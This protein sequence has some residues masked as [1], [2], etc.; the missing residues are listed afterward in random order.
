MPL[1]SEPVPPHRILIVDSYVEDANEMAGQLR[2]KGHTVEIAPD[3]P[4]ALKAELTFKPDIVIITFDLPGMDAITVAHR[5]RAQANR[6][7]ILVGDRGADEDY[8]RADQAGCFNSYVHRLKS[9]LYIQYGS[10]KRK[11]ADQS[12]EDWV[13]FELHA[14]PKDVFARHV[15]ACA[16]EQF[17]PAELAPLIPDEFL[18]EIRRLAESPADLDGLMFPLSSD[19]EQILKAATQWFRFFNP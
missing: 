14:Y 4:T 11:L 16:S 9:T 17:D 8:A 1:S 12:P 15:L 19:R 18:R 2:K 7:L 3:G 5:L 13:R 10:E 6:D